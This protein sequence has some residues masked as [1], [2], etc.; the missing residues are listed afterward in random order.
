MSER[1]DLVNAHGEVRA[2]RVLRTRYNANRERYPG[3]HLQIAVATVVNPSGHV[4]VH[5]R[6]EG[7]SEAGLIDLL[8]ETVKAGEEPAAAVRRGLADS[9]LVAGFRTDVNA[10]LQ[11]LRKVRDGAGVI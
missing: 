9:A 2:Y 6:A 1:V 5:E 11:K 10:A 4:L 7:K 8:C 3:L